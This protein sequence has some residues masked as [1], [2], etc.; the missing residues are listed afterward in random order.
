MSTLVLRHTVRHCKGLF[1]SI[2]DRSILSYP[3]LVDQAWL[4]VHTDSTNSFGLHVCG[5]SVVASAVA[6]VVV[7]SLLAHSCRNQKRENGEVSR[8]QSDIVIRC[9]CRS[10]PHHRSWPASATAPMM[11]TMHAARQPG[12]VVVMWW[13][14]VENDRLAYNLPGWTMFAS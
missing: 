10:T 1:I 13:P 5:H 4:L 14:L 7:V 3:Q 11:V 9:W 6:I 8:K 2:L 12:Q